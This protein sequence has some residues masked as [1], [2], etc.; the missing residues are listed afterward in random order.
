MPDWSYTTLTGPLFRRLDHDRGR[1]FVNG[2]FRL[3]AKVPG[4]YRMV[5]LL[6][7]MAP[8]PDLAVELPSGPALAS[9]LFLPPCVDPQG[10]AAAAFSRFGM[11]ALT[12]GPV[13]L[14][15]AAS[16]KFEQGDDG[17]LL[18]TGG[19][20]LTLLD[21]QTIVD[22][23][24]SARLFFEL[25][26]F[27]GGGDPVA[28]IEALVG[29]LG[30]QATALVVTPQRF[31]ELMALDAEAR[32]ALV[33]ALVAACARHAVQPFVGAPL[34]CPGDELGQLVVALR[35]H[36]AGLW[37]SGA[38]DGD[39][40]RWGGPVQHEQALEH[41]ATMAADSD[42]REP[43]VA[44]DAGTLSPRQALALWEAGAHLV[45]IGPGLVQ[46]GP[47]LAKRVNEAI[48]AVI[49]AKRA[50]GPVIDPRTP[51]RRA[52]VWAATLGLSMLV[53][54][55]LAGWSAL[56]TVLLPYDEEFLGRT[57]KEIAAFNPR[58]LEFMTH[59][60]I[61][62]AGT[63][64]SIGVLYTSLALFAMRRGQE[65]A[66]HV[67]A[68]SGALGA[69]SFFAFLGFGYLD[70]F[71]AFVTAVMLQFLIQV[72]VQHNAPRQA[73]RATTQLDNDATWRRAIWGQLLFVAHGGA[74]ILA[75][76]TI[77]TFGMTVVFVPQ[78]ISY[79]G[80]DAHAIQGFDPQLQALIAHDRAT[81]GGMLLAGGVALLLTSMWSFRRGE[82]W[83]FW[84]LLAIVLA[85]Y[86]MTLWIHWKIGYHDHFH[87]APV[88]IGVV[89]LVV[90]LVLSGPFLLAP[91][92][93][94]RRTR[95]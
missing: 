39:R 1:R 22:E 85:P 84:T 54:A 71:H 79:L 3:A 46:V 49:A 47:G 65:W 42:A 60:R 62:L 28:A 34:S 27:A 70:P 12:F 74:L 31:A 17:S 23:T 21:A 50:P 29:G 58:L 57:A 59:D 75:G 5:D 6:G 45:G 38:P 14:D 69:L 64:V 4:G 19:A 20:A 9:P 26:P 30:P 24:G 41:L 16:P 55:V 36:G 25:D 11:G 81:F 66:Q 95:P 82:R 94:R 7:H 68:A 72:A 86:V 89:L 48:H 32:D 92:D 44:V 61:T 56:T 53:G 73:P 87:L 37:L 35:T 33:G 52:W 90:A 78:D 93:T 77:L 51:M 8:D 15:E 80:C 2:F 10:H 18:G 67:V 91:G 40:Y 43:F 76:S 63:M 83:L 13:C 88:Y